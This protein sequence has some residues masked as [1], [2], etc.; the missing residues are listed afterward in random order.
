MKSIDE[1]IAELCPDGVEYKPLRELGDFYG[2]LTGKCKDDFG[3]G[4]AKFISYMNVYSNPATNLEV[5]DMVRIGQNEKQN[6][7]QYGDVL[8]TES[9]ETPEECAMSSVVTTDITEPIYLN[10]FCFGFRLFD[11]SLYHPGFL[12]HLL[13]GEATRKQL[14]KT[15][16]GVTRFN[17]SKQRMASVII[18]RPCIEIQREIVRILDGF[19]GLIDELEAELAARLKQY[20]QYR[21]KLLA[22][23]DDVEWKMLQDVCVIKHGSDYKSFGHG[24]YPVYGSGGIMTYVDRYAY[25]K[26]T[27]LLPR[28]GSLDKIHYVDH[29]FWNVDTVFYTEI[30]TSK[31]IPKFIYHYLLTVDLRR[32][33]NVGG[34]PGLTQ[35]RLNKIAV[36]HPSLSEQR[37]IV[38]T[39]DKFDALCNDE[40]SGLAAEI[41]A[42][43]KQYEYYRDRLLNF[44]RKGEVGSIESAQRGKRNSPRKGGGYYTEDGMERLRQSGMKGHEAA[45]RLI[46]EQIGER[47]RLLRPLTRE[48]ASILKS[49]KG[50]IPRA[51]FLSNAIVREAERRAKEE[52]I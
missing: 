6:Q 2:G 21:K 40:T 8:F 33:S 17:V 36:P 9:S 29:P 38:E 45:E 31:T 37:R 52:K 4:N 51:L 13:R 30:D 3:N 50:M 1:L 34:V 24:K 12:K 49:V 43:K 42:R 16:S 27:V 35:S 48:A 15:A 10:S 11:K 44:K 20:K 18:P 47:H 46:A 23:G 32:W 5:S 39:L 25:D 7:I 26:P 41:A 19:T 14:H 22:F 28:K